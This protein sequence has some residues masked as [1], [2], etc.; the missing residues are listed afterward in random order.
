MRGTL[1][2]LL[3]LA[4]MTAGSAGADAAGIK[5]KAT[6]TSCD[7]V[8]PEVADPVSGGPDTGAS[9]AIGDPGVPP[10]TKKNNL[11]TAHNGAGGGAQEPLCPPR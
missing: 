6:R 8:R 1:T 2:A 10:G 7:P 3:V 9:I 4:A 11:R 5:E